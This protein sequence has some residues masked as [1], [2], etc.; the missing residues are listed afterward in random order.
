M[1]KDHITLRAL[2]QYHSYNP[3]YFPLSLLQIVFREIYPYF[4]LW[5]S[6]EIVTALYEGRERRELYLLVAVTL[7][8]N[9]FVQILQAILKR[10]VEGALEVL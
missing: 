4:N 6:A 2:R 5:M 8:G 1:R 7:F 10:G 9:L 3:H